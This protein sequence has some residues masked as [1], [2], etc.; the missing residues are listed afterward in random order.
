VNTVW[1]GRFA[2][3]QFGGRAGGARLSTDKDG[4]SQIVVC[5]T[6]NRDTPHGIGARQNILSYGK[7]ELAGSHSLSQ[8]AAGERWHFLHFQPRQYT[9]V[10]RFHV[11]SGQQRMLDRS[12]RSRR[13]GLC[14]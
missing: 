9:R 14:S 11:S 5:V 8:R 13:I 1:N 12:G 10:P 3:Q 2:A 6:T 4:T 7:E